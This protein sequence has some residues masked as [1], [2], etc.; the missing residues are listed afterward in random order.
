MTAELAVALPAVALVLA[1]CLGAVHV[2]GRQ[3]RLTDAAADAARALG[4]GE[5]PAVAH[6]I[7]DRVAG[8]GTQ[9]STTQETPLICATV[10]GN[11]GAGVL[12]VIPLR[13]ESCAVAGGG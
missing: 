7:A 11:G 5:S 9:L 12:G 1:L 10:T 3:V 2:V 8:G 13:A 4:R 6:G